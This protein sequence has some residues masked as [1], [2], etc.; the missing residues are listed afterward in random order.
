VP[1]SLLRIT[2]REIISQV[3][4]SQRASQ[5]RSGVA[6]DTQPLSH[7]LP[8]FQATDKTDPRTAFHRQTRI[9]ILL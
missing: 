4:C 2:L 9:S 8:F 3:A 6:N 1:P 7:S 5:A